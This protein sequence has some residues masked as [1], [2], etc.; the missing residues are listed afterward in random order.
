MTLNSY[1]ALSDA[2]KAVVAERDLKLQTFTLTDRQLS[3]TYDLHDMLAVCSILL[4]VP[5]FVC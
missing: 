4:F 2:T 1:R 5:M 3:L